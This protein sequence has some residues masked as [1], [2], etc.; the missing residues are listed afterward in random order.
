MLR[1]EPGKQERCVSYDWGWRLRAG[2]LVS[3]GGLVG[4]LDEQ[5]RK[6]NG[7]KIFGQ[8][9]VGKE[10]AEPIKICRANN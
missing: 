4:N 3:L 10:G 8:G 7:T 6:K 5:K 9:R 1:L 2:R